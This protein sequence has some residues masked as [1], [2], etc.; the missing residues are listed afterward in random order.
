MVMDTQ[1]PQPEQVTTTIATF[2][3]WADTPTTVGLIFALAGAVFVGIYVIRRL[4]GAR[5]A[6][7]KV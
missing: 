6:E 5:G 4:R 1:T 7:K 2:Y 3:Q